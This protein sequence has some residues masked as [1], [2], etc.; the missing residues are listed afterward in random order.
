MKTT[1]E[2]N[3]MI[4]EFMGGKDQSRLIGGANEILFESPSY[5]GSK[6]SKVYTPFSNLKYH[7]SWDWLMPVV[8]EIDHLEYESE[9]LEKIDNAIKTRQIIA[10]HEAVVEFIEWYYEISKP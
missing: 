4:A 1:E 9:R 2:K 6:T 10:V 8:E 7:T 3:R 5:G